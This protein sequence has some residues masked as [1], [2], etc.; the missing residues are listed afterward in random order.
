VALSDFLPVTI[1][2]SEFSLRLPGLAIRVHGSGSGQPDYINVS[3]RTRP[4][5]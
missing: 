1:F 3:T 5:Y 2:N 4:D